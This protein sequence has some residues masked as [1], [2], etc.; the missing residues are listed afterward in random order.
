MQ[1]IVVQCMTYFS[2]SI[3]YLLIINYI[4]NNKVSLT[5]EGLIIDSFNCLNYYIMHLLVLETFIQER[6]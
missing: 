5:R 1:E 6:S 2:V 3:S 4:T